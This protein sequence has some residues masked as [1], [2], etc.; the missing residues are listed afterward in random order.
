MK[1]LQETRN[2]SVQ[3]SAVREHFIDM[4]TIRRRVAKIKNQWSVETSRA[5]ALEGKRRRG[6]LEQL[7]LELLTDTSESEEY[8]DLK[9]NGF[10]LVG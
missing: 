3:P 1:V 9:E 7:V 8:F 5:R 4:E 2:E 10:S 6:E